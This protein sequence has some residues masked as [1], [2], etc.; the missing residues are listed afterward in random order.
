MK[1]T[2]DQCGKSLGL[3]K[4]RYF[5]GYICKDCYKAASRN[6]TET[7]R[8]K[9]LEDISSIVVNASRISLDEDF[10]VSAKI[11]NFILIDK[12][13]GKFHI[14]D[15]KAD[16][17]K[18]RTYRFSDVIHHEVI[19]VPKLSSEEL[20]HPTDNTNKI[21]RSMSVKL[22]FNSAGIKD[23]IIIV[24]TPMRINSRAFR[25]SYGF[26]ERISSEF[27]KYSHNIQSNSC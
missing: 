9:S 1:K 8:E 6:F 3:I 5:T 23:E 4:F 13:R 22:T 16:S 24:S 10:K 21:I 18:S 20:N 11:G 14:I 15:R 27:Q 12:K 25:M 17:G 26:V 2:C 7:V 19:T